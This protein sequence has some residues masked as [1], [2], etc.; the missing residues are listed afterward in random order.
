ME[1]IEVEIVL[2]K[3]PDV[4]RAVEGLAAHLGLPAEVL[5]KAPSADLW[6]G[7]AD[8]DELGFSYAEVDRLL[9]PPSESEE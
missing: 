6:E 2:E 8:E 5:T 9:H 7:Q 3:L 1:E 4:P